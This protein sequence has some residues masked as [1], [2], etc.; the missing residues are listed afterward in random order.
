MKDSLQKRK[1][2]TLFA[3]T[4]QSFRLAFDGLNRY[5][6]AY[7][8]GKHLGL[9]DLL[10]DLLPWWIRLCTKCPLNDNDTIY[11]TR[12]YDYRH[13]LDS[14]LYCYLFDGRYSMEDVLN[15]GATEVP[16]M[17]YGHLMRMEVGRGAASG[18]EEVG[19]RYM[20][21]IETWDSK[22]TS[23]W[24]KAEVESFDIMANN[25]CVHVLSDGHEFGFNGMEQ[26]FYNYGNEKTKK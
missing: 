24:V 10:I 3:V 20:R 19:T 17:S 25:G 5:R 8:K 16:C 21:L 26:L 6:E 2:V 22:V 11:I 23:T 18:A 12:H 7:G 15:V 13:Q 4:D 14:M 9:E 1:E